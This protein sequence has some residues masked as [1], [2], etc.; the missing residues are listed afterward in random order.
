MA[1]SL[2]ASIQA[3]EYPPGALLP[4]ERELQARFSVSRTT[5][6]RALAALVESGWAE[7][8]P[9]RGVIARSGPSFR[10]TT[11]VA[12]IDHAEALNHRLFFDLT[13]RLQT[14]GLYLVHI[15]SAIHGVVGSLEVAAEQ[16]FAGAFVWSKDGFSDAD[17]IQTLSARVPI[18]ALDHG[19]R[20][21]NLD[22]VCADNLGGGRAA[23]D[24]LVRHGRRRIAVTGMTDML[25]INHERFAGWMQG[26]FANGLQPQARDIVWTFTSGMERSDTAALEARLSA[27]DRPD[28]LIVF[29]DIFV[30]DVCESVTR[31]GLRIPEDVAIV[32]FGGGPTIHIDDFSLTTI[33]FGTERLAEVAFRRLKE[34]MARPEDPAQTY[35]LPVA[36]RVGGSC[37]EPRDEWTTTVASPLERQ[38]KNWLGFYSLHI[39]TV[40][41]QSGAKSNKTYTSL[42][43]G[44]LLQ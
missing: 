28:A 18:V 39:R 24:H 12:F 13:C 27:E 23:V 10:G 35:V 26:L 19:I 16:G 14:A 31:C 37:G 20:G 38:S 1:E 3:N 32:A 22:L 29:G 41:R 21:A 44:D 17:R 40:H 36:V 8:L 4:T 34:K 33:E 11:N 9:N 43:S 6:R 15:D 30:P 7:L 2:R 5:V 25:E 42:M